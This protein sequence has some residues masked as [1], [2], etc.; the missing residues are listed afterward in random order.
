M[1]LLDR[2]SGVISAMQFPSRATFRAALAPLTE[3][4][5]AAIGST[6][7]VKRA[8]T[9]KRAD[10][11]S[12]RAWP[13]IAT[14]MGVKI[15]AVT[16]QSLQQLWGLE[17]GVIAEGTATD[18]VDIDSDDVVMVTAGDYTGDVY[19]VVDV[20]PRP[21]AGKILLGLGAPTETVT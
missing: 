9:V 11:S 5:V 16:E 20:K 1:G 3:A 10:N 14:G 2:D 17:S 8:T 6:V 21:L 15:A 13:L 18:A 4:V 12:T 19:R 7:D